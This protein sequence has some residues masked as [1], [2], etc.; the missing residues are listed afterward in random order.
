MNGDKQGDGRN[1]KMITEREKEKGKK[2]KREKEKGILDDLP[3]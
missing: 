1:E 2:G 3:T